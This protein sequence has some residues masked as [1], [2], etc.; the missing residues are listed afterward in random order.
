MLAEFTFTACPPPKVPLLS[1]DKTE[2][3][4]D[5]EG[6][7]SSFKITCD[8]TDWVVTGNPGWVEVTPS[9]GG[10][11]A[12]VVIR[13]KENTTPGIRSCMLTISSEA[14]PAFVNITQ[15]GAKDIL[16][17]N[18]SS[19]TSLVFSSNSGES[20]NVQITSNSNW[21]VSTAGMPDWI[22]VTP[23]N[24]TGN[25]ML[26]IKTT[27]S[28]N[29]SKPNEYTL[30]I[31]GNGGS[32]SISIKQEAGNIADCNATLS[33]TLT[34]SDAVA[35]KINLDAKVKYYCIAIAKT[36][37]ISRY[38]DD[39][40]LGV[41][42]NQER[43]TPDDK[44]FLTYTDGLSSN[45]SY[46]IYTI[47]IDNAGKH[48]DMKLTQIKTKSSSSQPLVYIDEISYDNQYWYW[49]TEKNP[50]CFDYYQWLLDYTYYYEPDVIVAWY[51]DKYI[52]E[53]DYSIISN[54]GGWRAPRVG[55]SFDLVTW[56]RS[57][58]RTM[59][60]VINRRA[61]M[62]DSNAKNRASIK[63]NQK[64]SSKSNGFGTTTLRTKKDFL[65]SI[66][67]IR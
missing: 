26:S 43:I 23:L 64:S 44:V 32:A 34:I 17:V 63:F 16:L 31:V 6:G 65:N 7:S 4:F 24:G 66:K 59:S 12:Q 45:T 39:E 58:D 9:S 53:G 54:G 47:G 62:L 21:S 41:L 42:L 27:K 55:N 14:S 67:Q 57:S 3:S 61:G 11:N 2:M 1:I 20:Q 18:G 10:S 48:G 50:F 35:F 22:S 13:A 40:I 49:V 60:G 28:N 5:A 56:G 38:T 15:E 52:G 46:N 29:N 30:N 8:Y 51:F 37:E 25:A 19:S 33:N 36:T